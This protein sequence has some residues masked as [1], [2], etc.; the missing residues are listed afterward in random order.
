MSRHSAPACLLLCLV[1]L[2]GC[3]QSDSAAPAGSDRDTGADAAADGR[4]TFEDTGA[5][6]DAPAA[7]TGNAGDTGIADTGTGD[8][9]ADTRIDTSPPDTGSVDTGADTSVAD[10]GPADPA[11]RAAYDGAAAAHDAATTTFCDCYRDGAPYN[12]NDATCRAELARLAP[13]W[14]ACDESVAATYPADAEAFWGC[15][16]QVATDMG[17]CFAGCAGRIQAVTGCVL[18][19]ATSA[20]ACGQGRDPAFVAAYEACHP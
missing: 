8:T 10:V 11:I 3:G 20:V 1:C 17:S 16:A 5:T 9:G 4:P 19:A 7:D 6:D 13:I 15:R 2:V 12:G 14:L 18:T